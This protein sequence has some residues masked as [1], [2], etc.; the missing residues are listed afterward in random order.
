MSARLA[1]VLAESKAPADLKGL[2]N[3]VHG[4]G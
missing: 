2:V 1:R 4:G 3:R